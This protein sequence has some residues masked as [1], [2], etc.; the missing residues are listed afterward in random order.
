MIDNVF[1][2]ENEAWECGSTDRWWEYHG[3]RIRTTRK[4]QGKWELKLHLYLEWK[5]DSL[6]FSDT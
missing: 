6:N 5:S 1:T 4:S 3:L 2:D